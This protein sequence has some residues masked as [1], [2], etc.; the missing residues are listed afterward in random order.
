MIVKHLITKGASNQAG[1]KRGG[2]KRV[3][4]RAYTGTSFRTK[5]RGGDG[6]QIGLRRQ[7][8]GANLATP[9]LNAVAQ[10]AKDRRPPAIRTGA[11]QKA[12]PVVFVNCLNRAMRSWVTG[13][14]AP[15]PIFF[16]SRLTIGMISAAVPVKNASSAA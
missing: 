1:L 16:A 3:A 8:L 13:P 12:T 11:A 14:G 7:R 5:H 2:L 9:G 4:I 15:Q 10:H 6:R